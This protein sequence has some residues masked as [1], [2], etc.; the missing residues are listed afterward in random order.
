MIKTV[1]VIFQV[2]DLA[3]ELTLAQ[4]MEFAFS[5][6][7][8]RKEINRK[9]HVF[10]DSPTVSY[11][12][13]S[14]QKE[15]SADLIKKIYSFIINGVCQLKIVVWQQTHYFIFNKFCEIH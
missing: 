10:V 13:F 14:I 2:V 5:I 8:N 3:S 4:P 1:T 9:H 11:V 7:L 6:K 15:S 12:M